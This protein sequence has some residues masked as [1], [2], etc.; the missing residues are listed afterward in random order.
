MRPIQVGQL[1]CDLTSTAGLAL[2]G[3]FLKTLAQMLAGADAVLPVCTGVTSSDI[4]R[5][6]LG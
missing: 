2:V 5:S 1:H 4:M 6:C 3:H